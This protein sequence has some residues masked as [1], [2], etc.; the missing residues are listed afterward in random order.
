MQALSV[1]VN[2]YLGTRPVELVGLDETVM[3]DY[4]G[5]WWAGQ[6]PSKKQLFDGVIERPDDGGAT[7]D[8]IDELVNWFSEI[9]RELDPLPTAAVG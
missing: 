9:L 6:P 1:R 8:A 5:E 7:D 2:A 4:D 3:D